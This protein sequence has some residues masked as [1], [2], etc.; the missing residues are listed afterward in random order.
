MQNEKVRVSRGGAIKL[1]RIPHA[2]ADIP[3]PF[4][5][6]PL[7][8]IE[9]FLRFTASKKEHQAERERGSP[10]LPHSPWQT[11]RYSSIII[12]E[13]EGQDAISRTI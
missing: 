3:S 9:A 12:E 10:S 7:T 1:N 11:G 13:E 2:P 4:E 8:E 6:T 5:A